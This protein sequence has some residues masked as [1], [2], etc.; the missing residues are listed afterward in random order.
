[1]TPEGPRVAREPE[2]LTDAELA[3]LRAYLNEPDTFSVEA[4]QWMAGLVARLDK[5]LSSGASQKDAASSE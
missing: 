2:P 5:A 4:R 1:M 3:Q